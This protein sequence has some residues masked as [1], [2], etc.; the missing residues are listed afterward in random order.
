MTE[1]VTVHEFRTS[2]QSGSTNIRND[3]LKT[4]NLHFETCL[5]THVAFIVTCGQHSTMTADT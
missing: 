2:Q 3:Q 5:L 4:E 1:N